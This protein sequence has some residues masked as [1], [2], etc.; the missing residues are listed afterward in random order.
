M[1]KKRTPEQKARDYEWYLDHERT[2]ALKLIAE[3]R[4][5]ER[6]KSRDAVKHIKQ[7]GWYK[8]LSL[9][10]QNAVNMALDALL[11]LSTLKGRRA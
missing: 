5:E 2:F 1:K 4:R 8:T 10:E 11:S 3:A 7:S 6:E 9:I